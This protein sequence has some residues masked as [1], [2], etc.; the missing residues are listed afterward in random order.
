MELVLDGIRFE[1]SDRGFVRA[2]DTENNYTATLFLKEDDRFRVVA[3]N[4]PHAGKRYYEMLYI[5]ETNKRRLY[6]EAV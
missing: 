3:S 2:V 6:G 1:V 5:A 4:F